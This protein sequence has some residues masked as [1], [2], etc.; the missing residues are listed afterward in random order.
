[1][2]VVH[3]PL[4]PVKEIVLENQRG[5]IREIVKVLNIPYGLTQHILIDILGMKPVARQNRSKGLH[6]FC[7]KY[8]D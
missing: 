2:R 6:F 7:E 3:S 1:M 5:H 4:F 8:I